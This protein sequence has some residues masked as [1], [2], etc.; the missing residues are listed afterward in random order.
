[1]TGKA[2][3][4]KWDKRRNKEVSR[5]V[6]DSKPKE[7]LAGTSIGNEFIRPQSE[8]DLNMNTFDIINLDR[9]IF[10]TEEGSGDNIAITETGIEAI[11][12]GAAAY[13]MKLQIPVNQVFQFKMGSVEKININTASIIL[14]GVTKINDNYLEMDAIT[15]PAVT[16]ASVRRLYVDSA[17]N[18]LKIR[19][20][21]STP[22]DLEVSGSSGANIELSNLGTTSVNA[23]II[24]QA[25]KILG[26]SGNEWA[27]VHTNDISFGT[28]G[29]VSAG[30]LEIIGD[31]GGMTFNIPNGAGENYEFKSNG[32]SIGVTLSNSGTL[33]VPTAQITFAA[34]LSDAVSYPG[35]NGAIYRE[36]N[37]V[38][39]FSGGTEINMSSIG[40]TGANIQLSN[41]GTTSVNANIIPQAGKIL[42]SSGNEWARVHSNNYRLGTAGTISNADNDIAGDSGGITF[43]VPTGAAEVF[44]WQAGGA[45]KMTLTS[46]GQLYTSI[47]RATT[48]VQLDDSTS[49]PGTNG[50]IYREGNDVKIF[51]GGTE[52]NMSSIGGAGA[53]TALNNLTTTSIN[54]SLIPSSTNSKSL[55]SASLQWQNL[56]IDGIARIDSLGFG[57]SYSMTLP[58]T[59]GTNGQVLT[60]NG[61]SALSWT[62]VSGGGGWNG[63]ATSDLDM[64]NFDIKEVDQLKFNVTGQTINT[65]STGLNYYVPSGD[66]HKFHVDNN[67]KITISSSNITF[68][69]DAIFNN[70]LQLNGSMTVQGGGDI[71]LTTGG[72]F[73]FAAD[74]GTP[75]TF[76]GYLKIKVAG[77]TKYIPYYS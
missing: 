40:S 7:I 39:I 77:A 51:T 68:N 44:D 8:S 33:V 19:T 23:N 73:D 3:I 47:L 37:D 1:M 75:S 60:T 64:N 10:A 63:S 36:G 70:T 9:M 2:D 11:A 12:T 48:V 52:V 74:T 31:S 25:G 76:T 62:T 58:T 46:G 5:S 4:R 18:H 15:A 66:S 56:F 24:P 28:A 61:S 29:N 43:N 13:G 38:K 20:D 27:R 30:G 57:A 26:S 54:Q 59:L 71:H 53:T 32:V 35:T 16:S 17:D 21:A 55:G 69:D 22:I 45:S 65:L 49:Y 72:R 67:L 50:S 34:V 41:L 42:G 6:R 14:N